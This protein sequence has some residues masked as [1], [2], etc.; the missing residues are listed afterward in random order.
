MLY[1]RSYDG[2][3]LCFLSN[4]EAQEALIEAHDGI[5]GAHQP[6][7]KIQDRLRWPGYYWPT[8]IADAVAYAKQCKT[9]QILADFIH[10]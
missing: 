2:I 10:D 6:G 4:S 8:M 5:C 1:Y 9:C 3:L 7:P